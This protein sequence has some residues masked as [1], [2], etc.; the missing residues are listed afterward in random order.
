MGLGFLSR[1]W[2]RVGC[3]GVVV[4]VVV[5]F[6]PRLFAMLVLGAWGNT[7]WEIESPTPDAFVAAAAP[8]H[9]SHAQIPAVAVAA[10]TCATCRHVP[11][12]KAFVVIALLHAQIPAVAAAAHVDANPHVPT[13]KAFARNVLH[14]RIP[15]VPA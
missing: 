10:M 3:D 15:A 8:L 14:A 11:M 12:L 9:Y 13:R 6:G 7:S 5:A 1:L 2:R 4:V